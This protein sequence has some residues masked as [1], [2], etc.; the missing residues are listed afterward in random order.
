MLL[1]MTLGVHAQQDAHFAHYFDMEPE[2]NPAAAGKEPRLNV[3]GAYALGLVGFE[4]GP[5]TMQIGADMPFRALNAFHGVG[6]QLKNDALGLFKQQQLALQ[7]ALR[8]SL[9]KGTLGVGVQGGFLSE[10]FNGSGVD[11]E[12][13]NDPALQR[14]EM[15][16][17]AIDM[18]A[19][20]Y[21]GHPR[22]YAG[23]SAQHL[24]APVISL[25]EVNEM[26][27]RPMYYFTGGYNIRFR[28]PFLSVKT[29][30]LARTDGTVWR[31]DLTARLCYETNGKVMYGGVSYA[32]QTSVTL[33][34]GGTFHGILFG[35]S[36]EAYT[37]AV[38]LVNGSH[39]LFVGYQTNLNFEKK[40]R[41]L[42]K[43]VRWL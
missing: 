27:L 13:A 37:S 12:E 14:A 23:L 2:F 21:Y 25:G 8:L 40:G 22:W 24:M 15:T 33:L 31:A 36:Y 43:S 35:Y 26:K 39:G 17:S 7:Y 34:L 41:N 1:G 20:I 30:V 6:V 16:G 3:T 4:H 42:H 28:R 38:S 19:G 5:R 10:T 18:G 29:S 32:P 9:G 11:V